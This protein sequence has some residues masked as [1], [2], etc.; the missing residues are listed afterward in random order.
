MPDTLFPNRIVL[1]CGFATIALL[2]AATLPWP[3]ALAS[4][5]LGTLM[6]AGADIDARHYLLPDAVTGGAVLAGLIAATVLDP[7]DRWSAF[8]TALTGSI[9]V[10]AG[11][12]LLRWIYQWLRQRE[13]I[14]LGDVKL[15]AAIGAWLPLDAVPL[16]FGLAS[17]AALVA[18]L[19]ARLRDH[20]VERTTRLPFGAFLCPALWLV[21]YVVRLQT[22]WY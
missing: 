4:T 19:L 6:V 14:G 21:D 12:W 1:A 3:Q 10:G 20:S 18:V 5:V 15:A 7:F 2:C 17:C 16:C 8:V 22:A 9:L 11:L 13:G